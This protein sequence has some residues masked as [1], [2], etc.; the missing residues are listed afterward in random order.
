M[1]K[2]SSS[3]L[4]VAA[5][6]ASQLAVASTGVAHATNINSAHVFVTDKPTQ[7]TASDIRTLLSRQLSEHALLIASASGAVIDK[8]IA[9]GDAAWKA[10]D[11]NSVE[12]SK[13]FGVVYG[14]AGESQFLP[15]WRKHIVFV[16]DYVAAMVAKDHTKADKAAQALVDYSREFAAFVAAANPNLPNEVVTT[17][18][19]GLVKEHV[20]GLKSMIDAQSSNDQAK[21]FQAMHDAHQHMSMIAKVL[22][23]VITKQFPAKYP[24]AI[25]SPDAELRVALN[26]LL[27]ERTY[28]AGMTT[29]A[30]LGGRAKEADAGANALLAGNTADFAAAV[31]AIYDKDAEAIF[32][33]LARAHTN[34]IVA[35]A[36]SLATKDNA[37]SSSAFEKMLASGDEIA[38]FFAAHTSELKAATLT[39]AFKSHNQ[40]LKDVAD[41]QATRDATKSFTILRS[42]YANVSAIAD[43]IAAGIVAQF[44]D[45]YAGK[46]SAP[47]KAAVPMPVTGGSL[48]STPV[49]TPQ[50][51][52]SMPTA[53]A[54]PSL[55]DRALAVYWNQT[56][57]TQSNAARF[58]KNAALTETPVRIQIPT[59]QLDAPI[60]AVGLTTTADGSSAEWRVPDYR[61][62]GWLNTSTQLGGPGNLVLSGHHN[63]EGRVFEY[64]KD[65]KLGDRI[66][67]VSAHRSVTYVVTTSEVLPEKDQ[68]EFVRAENAKLIAPTMDDR[69]TL[70]TCWPPDNNT[71]RLVVIARKV[72]SVSDVTT[73]AKTL[74]AE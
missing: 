7:L 30:V 63:I 43:P 59:I 19:A 5:I 2:P 4:A 41:A 34:T 12:L 35:Y 57:K 38:K 23:D 14:Q 50:S 13:S 47:A 45:K 48:G 67:V 28:L 56:H 17:L 20:L 55:L 52:L 29:D 62:A 44:P 70:V 54:A 69:L 21:A 61:A 32:L 22:A 6:L 68:P 9:D 65:V 66:T 60:V 37:T 8:R 3:L 31:G 49:A 18:A 71:H 74:R 27:A 25:D 73:T 24:G 72:L 33:P 46:T 16:Q 40:D 39:S 10:L 26:S 53:P 42:A 51:N 64:L 1:M 11:A 58:G 15:L 36:K